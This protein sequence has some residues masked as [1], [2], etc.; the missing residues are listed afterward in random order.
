MLSCYISCVSFSSF[1]L[2]FL[3][4][5]TVLFL[6]QSIMLCYCYGSVSDHFGPAF[7]KYGFGFRIGLRLS[8]PNVCHIHYIISAM[9]SGVDPWG[10]GGGDRP[11]PIKILGREYLF[12]PSNFS[13]T[14]GLETNDAKKNQNVQSG[15]QN[16]KKKI[17]GMPGTPNWGGCIQASPD[18]PPPLGARAFRASLVRL[19]P[20]NF[21]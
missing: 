19:P 8:K 1:L 21:D 5:C 13:P 11:S 4:I 10:G 15:M 16:L 20:K 6:F 17:G 14:V 2:V 3:T 18:H 9:S 12:A 7:N